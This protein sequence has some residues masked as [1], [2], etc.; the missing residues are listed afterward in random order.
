MYFAFDSLQNTHN[1]QRFK[2]IFPD[3]FGLNLFRSIRRLGG[4]AVVSLGT[5]QHFFIRL[6]HRTVLSA[7]R[8]AYGFAPAQAATFVAAKACIYGQ[9][10]CAFME[11]AFRSVPLCETFLPSLISALDFR[12]PRRLG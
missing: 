2:K 3:G 6:G 10:A 4:H 5:S 12:K 8:G 7:L 1:L 11:A 9:L